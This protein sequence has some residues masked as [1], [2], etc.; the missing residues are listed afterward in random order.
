[1]GASGSRAD[2]ASAV[3][4]EP[5]SDAS[6]A[7]DSDAVVSLRSA[8]EHAA[9]AIEAAKTA[10]LAFA[11]S[12]KGA[13]WG[14][15]DGAGGPF[16]FLPLG[17]PG[18]IPLAPD[19]IH[20]GMCGLHGDR[21]HGVF[22]SYS[23]GDPLVAAHGDALATAIESKMPPASP[24]VFF[25]PVPGD[26][27]NSWACSA[28]GDDW[29]RCCVSALSEAD[30]VVVVVSSY[31]IERIRRNAELDAKPDFLLTEWEV[32]V[33]R[34][35][36]GACRVL[37]VFVLEPQQE[38]SALLAELAGVPEAALSFRT[39]TSLRETF[40]A[41]TGFLGL[42]FRLRAAAPPPPPPGPVKGSGGATLPPLDSPP[43]PP[44]AASSSPFAQ[45]DAIAEAAAKLASRHRL[46]S[47]AGKPPVAPDAYTGAP[48]WRLRPAVGWACR[49]HR[50]NVHDVFISYRVAADEA[51]ARL[52]ALTI[53][54]DQR[55]ATVFLD[56]HCLLDGQAWK[57]GFLK[58][59]QGSK[60][61]ARLGPRPSALRPAC[62]SWL[63]GL[64][65]ASFGVGQL[66]E[67]RVYCIR[68]ASLAMLPALGP[69]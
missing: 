37:P 2:R 6:A 45:I 69:S 63:R 44:P 7:D 24:G 20:G 56:K 15:R 16:P 36:A 27:A 1:M 21:G 42:T 55:H 43:P 60:A 52:I 46:H 14:Q 53:E 54:A 66:S 61:R 28:P 30:A 49:R 3:S 50:T 17:L 29:E 39:G 31:A 67:E 18:G 65:L 38:L 4:A 68:V 8:A 57:E 51:L 40:G 48:T 35:R 34:E 13:K 25:M 64:I 32:A 59:M 58:G 12:A 11:A 22:I 5:D 10:V 62:D 23:T 47:R 26:R 41:I 19:L 33:A 9:S